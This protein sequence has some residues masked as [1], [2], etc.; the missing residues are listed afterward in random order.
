MASSGLPEACAARRG[1]TS[2]ARAA[3]ASPG[4][5]E[6][7][8]ATR[9]TGPRAPDLLTVGRDPVAVVRPALPLTEPSPPPAVGAGRGGT[10]PAGPAGPLG[11]AVVPLLAACWEGRA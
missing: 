9:A 2:A 8:R 1:R 5:D 6:G 7:E 10:V 4:P 11:D 3:P